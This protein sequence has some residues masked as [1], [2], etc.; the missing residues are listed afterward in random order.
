MAYTEWE[1]IFSYKN[2]NLIQKE[3][4]DKIQ[5]LREELEDEGLEGNELEEELTQYAHDVEAIILT[6]EE[7]WDYSEWECSLEEATE[8][9]QKDLELQEKNTENTEFNIIRKI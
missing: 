2:W 4:T 1:V 8:E 5:E 9:Y 3:D 7:N 6:W